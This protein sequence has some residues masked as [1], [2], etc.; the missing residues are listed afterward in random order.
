MRPLTAVVLLVLLHRALSQDRNVTLVEGIKGC[1]FS[2][3]NSEESVELRCENVLPLSKD[4]TNDSCYSSLFEDDSKENNRA[5]VKHLRTGQCKS[6]EFDD[7]LSKLFPNLISLDIS[8]LGL[9]HSIAGRDVNF[10]SLQ[11]LKASN[12]QLKKIKDGMFINT[13]FIKE[14]DFSFN[15]LVSIVSTSMKGANW[16]IFIN[17]SYNEIEY[18]QSATFE[19]MKNLQVID[20]SHNDLYTFDMSMFRNNFLMR[21]IYIGNNNIGRFIQDLELVPYFKWLTVFNAGGNHINNLSIELLRKL[22]GALEELDVSYSGSLLF[23]DRNDS[24]KG[25]RNLRH[26]NVAQTWIDNFDFSI[27]ENPSELRSIDLSYN[28]MQTIKFSTK[29]GQFSN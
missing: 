6:G 17:L 22:G 27:F 2:E 12:N 3:E 9:N 24:L 16:L 28:S 11:K 26:I 13:E 23:A 1:S 8:Y 10:K 20:L 29:N 18:L 14:I 21:K 19:N 15:K 25:F 7:T 4:N 5:K